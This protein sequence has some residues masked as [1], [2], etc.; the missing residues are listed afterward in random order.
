MIKKKQN[1]MKMSNIVGK[2]LNNDWTS[3][4]IPGME[5]IVLKGLKIRMTL[6][7]LTLFEETTLEIHPIITTTKSS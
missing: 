6:I 2:E 3:L 5:L 1:K 4:L 7:A